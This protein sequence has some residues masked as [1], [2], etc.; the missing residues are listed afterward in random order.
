MEIGVFLL[1]VFKSLGTSLAGQYV[2]AFWRW[3]RGPLRRIRELHARYN[4]L[5]SENAAL[6]ER[7]TAL[8]HENAQVVAQNQ[9]LVS[10]N[11]ALVTR[12]QA[13]ISE[14]A[15][16]SKKNAE[17]EK[18]LDNELG[19]HIPGFENYQ[20][21]I[22]GYGNVF[23]EDFK[24]VRKW[25]L[26]RR[27]LVSCARKKARKRLLIRSLMISRAQ[28]EEQGLRVPST[29]QLQRQIAS[30]MCL[31]FPI[32]N[33]SLPDKQDGLT[34]TWVIEPGKKPLMSSLTPP[35]TAHVLTAMRAVQKCLGLLNGR[36]LCRL[37]GL[38]LCQSAPIPQA[39]A[40]AK[41]SPYQ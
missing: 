22:D 40:Q 33:S 19:H 32:P 20:K 35:A 41:T 9:Q 7:N 15:A 18:R 4:A 38:P 30:M 29:L 37:D 16:L 28:A 12:N 5:V 6:I 3:L 27:A 1:S 31:L 14:N 8:V 24:T 11:A 2:K 10:E 17:L 13:L 25:A 26:N 39:Q 23:L 36:R 21:C 34:R